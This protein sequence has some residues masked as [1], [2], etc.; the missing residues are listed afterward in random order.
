MSDPLFCFALGFLTGVLVYGLTVG[1]SYEERVRW[2]QGRITF[3]Y[4]RYTTLMKAL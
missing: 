3:W 1:R 4:E 2:L